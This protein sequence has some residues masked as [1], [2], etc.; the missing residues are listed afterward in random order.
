M[1][2]PHFTIDVGD[3]EGSVADDD[4]SPDASSRS[5][6]PTRLPTCIV[7][8]GF[9]VDECVA[10]RGRVDPRRSSTRARTLPDFVGPGMRLLVCG[11]NPSVY[12]ADAGV[13]FARPGNRFWPA[14]L[15][16]GL[17]TR[18]RDPRHALRRRTASA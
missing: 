4:A 2:P 10:R 6:R 12:A 1:R 7:G 13:G 3:R 11:L 5:G 8:A 9:D 18:D 17:V 16:A 15:A 14:A